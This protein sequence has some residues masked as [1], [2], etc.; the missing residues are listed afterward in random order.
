M[1]DRSEY[2]SHML[3]YLFVSVHA[4]KVMF[5]SAL[6]LRS[7]Y[8]ASDEIPGNNR[9]IMSEIALSPQLNIMNNKIKYREMPPDCNL[10]VG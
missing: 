10:S 4:F 2:I 7:L 8:K 1:A 5:P 9:I 6:I 3:T